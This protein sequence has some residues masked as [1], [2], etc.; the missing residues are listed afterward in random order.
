MHIHDVSYGTRRATA[1]CVCNVVL[2]L[3]LYHAV[4]HHLKH[5]SI[6]KRYSY[7]VEPIFVRAISN[8]IR[9]GTDPADIR[10]YTVNWTKHDWFLIIRVDNFVS[11][12]F[13]YFRLGSFSFLLWRNVGI[14]VMMRF[15][16]LARLA[17]QGTLL[18]T[19]RERRCFI[20]TRSELPRINIENTKFLKTRIS[21]K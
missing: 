19:G 13:R 16:G 14:L 11:T 21:N 10:L 18:S 6:M 20:I 1:Q 3:F 15:G 4:Y 9:H 12:T 7:V 8:V 17:D 5:D 2:N